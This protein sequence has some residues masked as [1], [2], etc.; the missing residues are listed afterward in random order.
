[1]Y[2]RRFV[3]N[4]SINAVRTRGMSPIKINVTT[5]VTNIRVILFLSSHSFGS[6]QE[7]ITG[8]CGRFN[9]KKEHLWLLWH[10][11]I[12]RKKKCISR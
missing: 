2:A 3:L 7:A 9:T 10:A 11:I 12:P 6:K 5:P 8:H 4:P 1:M